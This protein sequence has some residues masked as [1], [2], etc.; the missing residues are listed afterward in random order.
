MLGIC[1][2]LKKHTVD[3]LWSV[4]VD[5]MAELF[6]PNVLEPTY[7]VQVGCSSMLV[8]KSRS[9][10]GVGEEIVFSDK[11]LLAISKKLALHVR[12]GFW[13]P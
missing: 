4:Q 12:V 1:H 8:F 2:R 3:L 5:R 13:K 9:L 11:Q 7:Y 6:Y 10:V